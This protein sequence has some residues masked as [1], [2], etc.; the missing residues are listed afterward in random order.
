MKTTVKG[1][2][3]TYRYNPYSMSNLFKLYCNTGDS[4]ADYFT[5][6]ARN[7]AA[8]SMEVY[9][10]IPQQY[11]D[12][13]SAQYN[14]AS[15]ITSLSQSQ[16]AK[17]RNLVNEVFPPM[18]SNKHYDS[19]NVEADDASNYSL[20]INED[21][22][23][24][25]DAL[26]NQNM[27][28]LVIPDVSLDGNL[29]TSIGSN[30]HNTID[31][32]RAVNVPSTIKKIPANAF[33]NAPTLTMVNLSYGVE[34]IGDEVFKGCNQLVYINIPDTVSE[35]GSQALQCEKLDKVML[36][37]NITYLDDNVF[38]TNKSNI[39]VYT[40][41]D[42]TYVINYCIANDISYSTE[43]F[44]MPPLSFDYLNIDDEDTVPYAL[45]AY[46]LSDTV[47]ADSL[48]SILN[49][50]KYYIELTSD[51]GFPSDSLDNSVK[52]SVVSFDLYDSNGDL[53]VQGVDYIY[54]HK[55]LYLLNDYANAELFDSEKFVMKNIAIDFDTVNTQLGAN[56]SLP[57]DDKQM[58]KTEYCEAVKALT[59]QALYGPLLS[60]VSDAA[61]AYSEIANKIN[62]YD[63]L[64][65]PS[66]IRK[67]YN[68]FKRGFS[69]FDYIL[70][71]DETLE[72]FRYK[73]F[74]QYLRKTTPP[75]TSF[76][77][78]AHGEHDETYFIP[79]ETMTS[80]C[81]NSYVE[82]YAQIKQTGVLLKEDDPSTLLNNSSF[83]TYNKAPAKEDGTIQD[84]LT[85]RILY[86][87][88]NALILTVVYEHKDA[89]LLADDNAIIVGEQ[90][91]SVRI[92]NGL[93]VLY[94]N[95]ATNLIINGKYVTIKQKEDNEDG[96]ET[97]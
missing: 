16:Q 36:S 70:Y 10:I 14:E 51:R 47:D 38:G 40:T 17:Y 28:S 23:T 76:K 91:K 94:K 13:S 6:L 26:I 53:M 73:I 18:N 66:D 96:T 9:R 41:S 42:S 44:E 83:V 78:I 72:A 35:I 67:L 50:Y 15:L 49:S 89:S 87:L 57:F 5:D 77:T 48:V 54:R 61:L 20:S 8:R 4:F 68:D 93:N 29:V 52:Y 46:D 90:G 55:R 7:V 97:S 74:H 75:E 1:F 2:Y 32:I 88:R 71:V 22:Y 60:N 86:A 80:I 63:Y 24:Q 21:G 39:T 81:A 85:D 64:N 58:A 25:V 12:I 43:P 69:R 3:R 92:P 37:K 62:I 79:E 95:E 82:D 65:A 34:I 45:S 30:F 11:I 59:L 56:L 84:E 27:T 19:W 33:S 31:R